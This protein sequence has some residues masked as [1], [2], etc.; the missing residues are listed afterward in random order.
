[1]LTSGG[2]WG[3]GGHGVM[4][5]KF[6]KGDLNPQKPQRQMCYERSQAYTGSFLPSA[7]ELMSLVYLKFIARKIFYL[8]IYIL[9]SDLRLLYSGA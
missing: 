4:P 7:H 8:Y 1:M 2:S 9:K 3:G 5:P 6:W